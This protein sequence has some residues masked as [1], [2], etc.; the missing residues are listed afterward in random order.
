MFHAIQILALLYFKL[1]IHISHDELFL[2]L[3]LHSKYLWLLFS[4]RLKKKKEKKQQQ[5][6]NVHG[7]MAFF[8]FL[9][10]FSRRVMVSESL[11]VVGYAVMVAAHHRSDCEEQSQVHMFCLLFL[12]W[13]THRKLYMLGSLLDQHSSREQNFLRY[14]ISSKCCL[15][16]RINAL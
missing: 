7:K 1:I 13:D 10:E 3:D 6:C 5:Y 15:Q 12:L 9:N 4:L 2:Y 11:Y 8:F 14:T 16:G